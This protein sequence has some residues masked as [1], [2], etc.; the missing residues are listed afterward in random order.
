MVTPK[1]APGRST[2]SVPEAVLLFRFGSVAGEPMLTVVVNGSSGTVGKTTIDEVAV[3]PTGSDPRF[4]DAPSGPIE[5][6]PAL[7]FVPI[8]KPV[9]GVLFNCTTTSEAALV[10]ELVA[11][12]VH[13]K[14]LLATAAEAAGLMV[15]PRS[16]PGHGPGAGG[17]T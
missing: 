10:P 14:L 2:K 9:P 8:T 11:T 15:I 5:I 3:L 13:T 16:D 12:T 1:S 17:H 7:R 4:Q 6:V